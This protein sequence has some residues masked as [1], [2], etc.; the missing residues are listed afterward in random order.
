M[1]LPWHHQLIDRM[2]SV[3]L[4]TFAMRHCHTYTRMI[5]Y[6]HIFPFPVTITLYGIWKS[7]SRTLGSH[8]WSQYVRNICITFVNQ[9]GVY[10][11]VDCMVNWKITIACIL[12]RKWQINPS[13]DEAG[14]FQENKA[15]TIN[16]YANLSKA[17]L[18]TKLETIPVWCQMCWMLALHINGSVVCEWAFS[19]L[20]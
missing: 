9:I 19:Q 5:R 2:A 17:A 6:K 18:L 3:S 15:N 4:R 14:I 10:F 11:H 8:V 16:K 20:S 12:A 1:P 7:R 13:V